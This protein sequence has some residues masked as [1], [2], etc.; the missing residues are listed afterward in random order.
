MQ[1]RQQVLW[2][3]LSDIFFLI[4][5]ILHNIQG[6]DT[7]LHDITRYFE[8][9]NLVKNK[10]F[11]IK[12]RFRNLRQ[13]AKKRVCYQFLGNLSF[14]LSDHFKKGTFWLSVLF[15]FKNSF[16]EDMSRCHEELQ[17]GFR[18]PKKLIPRPILTEKSPTSPSMDFTH[19]KSR[20][21]HF[22]D[23]TQPPSW[24]KLTMCAKSG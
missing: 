18:T 3:L 2:P 7:I 11:F 9:P 10:R 17:M 20:F 4:H 1:K 13:L 5:T 21:E 14:P 24:S 8:I 6:V 15:S 22:W 16:Y 19:P 23:P 12:A